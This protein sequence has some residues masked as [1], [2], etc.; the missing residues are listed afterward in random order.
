MKKHMFPIVI[1]LIYFLVFIAV[2]PALLK[3]D[4]VSDSSEVSNLPTEEVT[5]SEI[6]PE[7]HNTETV[8]ETELADTIA[9]TAASDTSS[10]TI[11]TTETNEDVSETIEQE[12]STPEDTS[13]IPAVYVYNGRKNLN[14]RSAPSKDAA[15]L[16]KI[17]PS[18]SLTI[19]SFVDD[20]WAMVDYDGT[21]GYCVYSYLV[22]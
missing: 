13:S 9:D 20:T 19:L 2:F 7:T 11:S 12:I 17:P 4:I 18:D 6:L 10:D 15:I 3:T 5:S 16:S 14:L 21:T 8:P 1:C 22:Y